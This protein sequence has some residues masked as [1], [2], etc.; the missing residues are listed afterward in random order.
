MCSSGKK[1]RRSLFSQVTTRRSVSLRSMAAVAVPREF[2][3]KR[4]AVFPACHRAR[5]TRGRGYASAGAF[6][7]SASAPATRPTTSKRCRRI[8]TAYAAGESREGGARGA[9]RAT[10]G[11]RW[12]AVFALNEKSALLRED[13]V[14]KRAGGGHERE[15]LISRQMP[16]RP[17]SDRLVHGGAAYADLLGDRKRRL[18]G[19]EPRPNGQDKFIVQD[20]L[21]VPLAVQRPPPRDHVSGVVGDAALAQMRGVYTGRIIAVVPDELGRVKEVVDREGESVR[22]PRPNLPA[23]AVAKRSVATGEAS[24]SPLPA[25]VRPADVY[26]LPEAIDVARKYVDERK[27]TVVLEHGAVL[28]SGL[29]RDVR[30]T[31]HLRPPPSRQATERSRGASREERVHRNPV[32]IREAS[33]VLSARDHLA[34]LDAR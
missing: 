14:V 17:A 13:S 25:L 31:T 30:V 26:L 8:V 15:V 4:V 24:G 34:G 32:L 29:D 18:A 6:P 21:V 9:T 3:A 33:H 23:A 22:A 10:A 11:G 16:P 5:I 27:A 1:T 7:G 28:A 20:G 12:D 2:A 19:A